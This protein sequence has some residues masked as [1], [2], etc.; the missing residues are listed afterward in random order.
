MKPPALR[1][2]NQVFGHEYPSPAS[3]A[4]AC[5]HRRFA[6]MPL[7]TPSPLVRAIARSGATR[8]ERT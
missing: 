7:P 1:I 8:G 6:G 2:R 5:L 3:L 4:F